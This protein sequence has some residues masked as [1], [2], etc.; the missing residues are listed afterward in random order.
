VLFGWQAI[1]DDARDVVICEGEIDALS[2][3][4][5][6]FPAMSVPYGGGGGDKQAWIESEYDRL[7]RFE[8][9]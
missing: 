3:A 6:G 1:P 5:Y 4:A 7:E 9:I 8:R 2:W